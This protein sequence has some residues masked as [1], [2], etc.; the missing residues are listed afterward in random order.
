MKP[1]RS[2]AQGTDVSV[3]KS[4]TQIDTMLAKNGATSIGSLWGANAALLVFEMKGRKIKLTLPLPQ[5]SE[6]AFEKDGRGITRTDVQRKTACDAEHRRLWRAF[7]LV[8]QAKME[9]IESGMETF[10]QAFLAH[11]MA[12]DG[13]TVGEAMIPQLV[14]AYR[15][16]VSMPPLL[17][18]G[19]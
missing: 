13:Q 11:I 15:D 9:S 18:K 2:F 19:R 3:A 10:E 8:L 5:P 14:R 17:G 4:R 1:N 12:P 16:G 6:P 7:R